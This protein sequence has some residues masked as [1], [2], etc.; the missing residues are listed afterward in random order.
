MF[1]WQAYYFFSRRR[2]YSSSSSSDS[3]SSVDGKIATIREIERK[4]EETKRR[5]IEEKREQEDL[6]K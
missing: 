5:E 1:V 2:D 4:I 6:E 3:S